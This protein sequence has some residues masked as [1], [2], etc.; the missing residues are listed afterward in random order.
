[1]TGLQH[2][3]LHRKYEFVR[4]GSSMCTVKTKRAAIPSRENGTP[5]DYNRLENTF[6]QI[7]TAPTIYDRH[8][9]TFIFN[10]PCHTI[11]IVTFNTQ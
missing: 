5:P 2:R 10:I 11:R 8:Q 3:R 1:M 4:Y 9:E 7:Y 6:N